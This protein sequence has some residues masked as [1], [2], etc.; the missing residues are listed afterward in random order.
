VICCGR[1]FQIR[2]A[3]TGKHGCC[4]LG[5]GYREQTVHETKQ[6]IDAFETPTLLDDEL[7]Q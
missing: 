4:R 6:N 5:V 2:T 1:L 3:A 7:R